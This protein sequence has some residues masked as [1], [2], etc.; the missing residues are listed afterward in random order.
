MSLGPAPSR[1]RV[2]GLLGTRMLH[3]A[4]EH[5]GSPGAPAG[6]SWPVALSTGGGE[7]R[8]LCMTMAG[9]RADSV[10]AL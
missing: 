2:A 5:P 4:A 6:Q 3:P 10:I 1:G 7:R 9:Q 8:P